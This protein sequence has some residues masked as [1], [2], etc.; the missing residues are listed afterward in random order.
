MK[1]IITGPKGV[2]K[3]TVGKKIADILH[4]P[5]LETDEIIESLFEKTYGIKKTCRQI[6]KECGESFFRKLEKE[7]IIQASLYDWCIIA[8]GGGTMLFPEN[9]IQLR[10]ES[11]FVLLKAE[12][13]FLWQRMQITG[14]PP[15]LQGDDAF[16]K[17]SQRVE[18]LYEAT[19]HIS[20]IVYTVSKENENNAYYDII[21]QISFILSQ[22]MYAPN[23]FGQV[24]R[25][26]TFG[27]SHGKALGAV[28]DGL[29]PGIPLSIED[30]Q[31][32]LD[33]RRPG[34]S[35]VSTKRKEA[36]SVDIVSGLFE[37]KTT[38]TPLCMI[39]Y[40]K[41]QDSRAYE[42]IKDIF[43][44]GH[45]DFTFWHKYGMRDYRGGG[46]SSGRETVG[47]VA[48]GAIALKILKD[49]GVT[50]F[51]YAEEIAGIKGEN[52]N[53]DFIEKNPVRAADPDKAYAMEEAIKRAQ[54]EHDSVGGI[55]ACVVKG[56]PAGVGDPVFCKLDARLAMAVMSIGAVKGVEFGSGFEAARKRGS[57][58][59]DQMC[60]GKF[61]TNN[62]GGILGGISTGQDIMMR[63]AVK[64]T[65]SIAKTQK[66]M[67]IF[68]N[69][70]DVSIKGRHDP[71]IVPRIIPV[72]EAMV[73]LVVYDAWLLQERIGRY[74]GT[75]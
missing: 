53:F 74:D 29:K 70:V 67:D 33:R 21:Q 7:A 19:E 40:N 69:T 23:T 8:T 17:Y 60:D 26:T 59:N 4:I 48:A 47:R 72:V 55:V 32:Q 35:T 45:A 44:P 12:L 51:A 18:K 42:S 37:G 36:D 39:V 20:D 43:R 14:I 56:L 52:V 54:A 65:P 24:L 63:I 68:G 61:L 3:S 62:A 50:I 49:K 10:K 31:Q 71:C 75:V 57:E 11:I 66:T 58:N 2:G 41:D 5:F 6:A 13:D 64:P 28:V 34:Q 73:A 30:I 38:G 25:V 1:I 46:R 15:F 9:R 27:E 22:Y 16:I